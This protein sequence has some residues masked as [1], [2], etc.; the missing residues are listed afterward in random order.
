MQRATV[1][2]SCLMAMSMSARA[3]EKPKQTPAAEELQEVV[4]TGSRIA[5][6]DLDRLEP[7][8]IVSS[9]T[10]DE[11]TRDDSPEE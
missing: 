6:P 3:Q 7:T 8:M 11:A 2:V 1:A 10:F 9:G 4:V 5:R